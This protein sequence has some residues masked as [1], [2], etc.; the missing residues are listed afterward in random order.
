MAARAWALYQHAALPRAAQARVHPQALV[1]RARR[2]VI[3]EQDTTRAAMS[4]VRSEQFT[5][6]SETTV[7]PKT[8]AERD[9]AKADAVRFAGDRAREEK[10]LVRW[11]RMSEWCMI[12]NLISPLSALLHSAPFRR[13]ST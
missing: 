12:D 1:Q 4:L 13:T 10:R 11:L 9:K 2:A 5:Y 3:L 6:A 7:V 8:K